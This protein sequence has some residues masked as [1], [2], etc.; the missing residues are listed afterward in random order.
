MSNYTLE[1]KKTFLASAE[2]IY[3]AWLD[4]S[5]I[6]EFMR[7]AD[8]ITIPDPKVDAKVGGAF[9]FDMHAGESILPH[10]GEYIILER[11]KKIQFTWNSMNTDNQDSIVTITISSLGEDS[12]E[13]T[14]L[15][16]KLPSES[17][18]NDHQGGWNN[19]LKTLSSVIS[20]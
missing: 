17:S 14:L 20:N 1:L 13:L 5:A 4:P 12:C 11:P 18:R 10:K 6:K 16:E 3:D 8:V 7:P 2:T 19:I 15:H 9:L